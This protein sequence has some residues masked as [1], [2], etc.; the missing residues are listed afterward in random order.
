MEEG[1]DLS[2]KA[3]QIWWFELT[4]KQ[5]GVGRGGELINKGSG[6]P[7]EVA[8]AC[9]WK[10]PLQRREGRPPWRPWSWRKFLHKEKCPARWPLRS[11]LILR[12]SILGTGSGTPGRILMKKNT[13]W[14]SVWRE[15]HWD[16]WELVC[17]FLERRPCRRLLP[18]FTSQPLLPE[19][20]SFHIREN[21]LETKP[22]LEKIK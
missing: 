18:T 9:H 10:M 17:W 7:L 6:L 20:I 13:L 2:F 16:M 19:L 21:A 5:F 15:M 12:F 11:L 8:N 1:F 4:G 14:V 22:F 3:S